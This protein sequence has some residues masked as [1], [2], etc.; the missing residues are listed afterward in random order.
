MEASRP[1]CA[2]VDGPSVTQ[3]GVEVGIGHVAS[4]PEADFRKGLHCI[5][6]SGMEVS[7]G[8]RDRKSS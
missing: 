1:R 8:A 7:R 6:L 3:M 4:R 5:Y 2:F